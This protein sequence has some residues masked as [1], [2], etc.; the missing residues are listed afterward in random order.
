MFPVSVTTDFNAESIKSEV[1]GPGRSGGGGSGDALGGFVTR[2]I[3]TSTLKNKETIAIYLDCLRTKTVPVCWLWN[4]LVVTFGGVKSVLCFGFIGSF[5][6]FVED[7]W[8]SEG[9]ENSL[10]GAVLEH[11]K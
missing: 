7:F 1:V 11:L 4:F 2:S 8:L 9:G 6:F 10:V 3:N 5:D